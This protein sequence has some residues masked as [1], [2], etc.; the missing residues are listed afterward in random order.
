MLRSL[1]D[2]RLGRYSIQALLGRGGMAAVYRALDT[3][4]QRE[5]ALKLLYPQYSD[6]VSLV[7][8]FKREA[9]TAASLEHP[10]IVPV[11]DVG[12][13][14]DM[15]YFAMKLLHGRTM[16]DLLAERGTLSL[17]ELI[18]ILDPVASA[19]DYAHRRGVVHRDV[20]PGNI[21]LDSNQA[22]EARVMLTDFGIA[23]V[24]DS[25]NTGLT[26]TGALI[27][28]PD[29]M[30][31]EQIAA[32]PIDGR[33]DVYALGMVAF[34]ALTGRRA[35][36]GSTQDVLLGHLY[37]QVPRPSSIRPQLTEQLD[38]VIL[39]A[40]ANDPAQR[41][42]TAGAFVQALHA[43]DTVGMQPAVPRS[44]A[45]TQHV[46]AVAVQHPL[47]PPPQQAARPAAATVVQPNYPAPQ[48]APSAGRH[49]PNWA[50]VFATILAIALVAVSAYVAFGRNAA[51]RGDNSG[52]PPVVVAA[53]ATPSATATREPTHIPSA[54]AAVAGVLVSATARAESSIT[55]SAT[56]P[57]PAQQPWCQLHHLLRLQQRPSRRQTRLSLA[58]LRRRQPR[59]QTRRSP[60]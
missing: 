14:D 51:T 40:V 6:D 54:T 33:V 20:K 9:V 29:Y 13:Q 42:A 2:Q 58:Q 19:L 24:V 12:A 55:P 22:G 11:Y 31:P 43:P 37:Q 50:G 45:P 44:D 4:L 26:T 49:G 8:R 34:R 36:E 25:A 17:A 7:E 59:P 52:T 27:G 57:R 28:T 32:R 5:V 15:V 30:A 10:H 38:A 21:F 18:C 16:Q 60:A 35:F 23:K 39:R 46:M 41:F 48:R 3:V 53:S 1:I 56:V 47:T